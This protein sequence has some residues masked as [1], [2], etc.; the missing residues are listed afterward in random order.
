LVDAGARAPGDYT[1]KVVIT[2]AGASLGSFQE[3]TITVV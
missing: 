1:Y 3:T 2:T